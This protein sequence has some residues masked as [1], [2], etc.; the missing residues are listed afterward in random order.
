MPLGAAGADGIPTAIAA[1]AIATPPPTRKVFIVGSPSEVL[2]DVQRATTHAEIPSAQV[3]IRSSR[4]DSPG[5]PAPDWRHLDFAWPAADRLC[6]SA[7][8]RQPRRR[9]GT[10]ATARPDQRRGGAGA[11]APDRQEGAEATAACGGALARALPAGV[12][13]DARAG[14]PR[15]LRAFGAQPGA[16]RGSNPHPAGAYWL[17]LTS[18][19]CKCRTL[20]HRV[21]A[22]RRD[23]HGGGLRYALG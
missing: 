11:D 20:R 23:E 22:G 7:A 4:L 12:R 2:T 10:C 17:V 1:A 14:G 5:R 15:R 21:P 3:R 18:W 6:S 19:T 9:R 8:E 16:A 13:A